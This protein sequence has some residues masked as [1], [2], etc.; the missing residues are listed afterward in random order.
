VSLNPT[1]DSAVPEFGFVIVKLSDVVPFNGIDPAPN[2]FEIDGAAATVVDAEA[3]LLAGFGSDVDEVAEAVF[4]MVVPPATF[5]STFTT[6]V[7]V[8]VPPAA[9]VGLVAVMFPVPPTAGV[10]VVQPAGAVNETKVVLAGTASVRLALSASLGPALLAVIVYVML[11]PGATGSGESVFVTDRFADGAATVVVSVS[12]LLL[13]SS[14]GVEDATVA[15]LLMVVPGAV[16]G[17]TFTTNV[18]VGNVVTATVPRVHVTVAV[19]VQVPCDGVAETKVVPAGTASV[20]VT[21]WASDGPLFWTWMAYERLAP[22]VTGSG[23]SVFA[24]DTFATA[25]T[26]VEA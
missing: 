21:L 26:V 22:G 12:E 19:P 3:E 14:S 25:V 4:V 20:R 23:E 13:E 18:T 7:K 1:P 8:A 10:V 6:S 5:A 11:A 16:P 2:A 24:T 17:F 9:K 15:V